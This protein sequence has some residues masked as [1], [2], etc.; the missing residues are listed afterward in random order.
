MS[1]QTPEY[2]DAVL[3]VGIYGIEGNGPEER[4]GT[5]RGLSW[6]GLAGDRRHAGGYIIGTP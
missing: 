2:G 3:K 4:H 5:S 6:H 1:V